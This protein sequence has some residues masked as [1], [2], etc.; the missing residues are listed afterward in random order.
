MNP[1]AYC[2][3]QAAQSGSSFYYSFLFLPVAQREAIMALYAFCRAVDD[4]VDTVTDTTIASQ[5]LH[6]WRA[7]IE[8][9]FAADPANPA[10]HPICLAL[11]APAIY[12]GLKLQEFYAVIAGME[13]DLQQ[14]CYSDDETL[15]IYCWR[16]ASV[17]GMMSARIFSADIKLDCNSY[18]THMGQALQRINIIRDV[19]EDALLGRVYLPADLLHKHGL[20]PADVLSR[21]ASPAMTTVLQ[22]MATHAWQH[23]THA[24]NALEALPKSQ[25]KAQRS[26]LIMARVYAA[27]LI[28]IEHSQFLVLKQRISLTPIKKLWLAWRTWI[29]PQAAIK[30]LHH[31]AKTYST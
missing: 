30:V 23:L 28:E 25:I 10:T 13:M 29:A 16:V 31:L 7:E 14:Q 9:M 22:V 2:R 21:Q 12:Y 18:A 20:K 17:V 1:N 3:Q 6:W 5:K 24:L 11:H 8:R 26:G 15:S 27:L 19:G 4:V